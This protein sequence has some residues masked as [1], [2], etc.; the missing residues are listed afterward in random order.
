[1][2]EFCVRKRTVIEF[3]VHKRNPTI[4]VWTS[5][6]LCGCRV[7]ISPAILVESAFIMKTGLASCNL[8][9]RGSGQAVLRPPYIDSL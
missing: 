9:A 8:L 1:M 4:D 7:Q 5:R 6:R 2:V 3:C